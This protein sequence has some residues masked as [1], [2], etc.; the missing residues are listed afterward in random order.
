MDPRPYNYEFRRPRYN[1]PTLYLHSDH[2]A[3]L[4]IC[5]KVFITFDPTAGTLH[6][7]PSQTTR[8]TSLYKSIG[9]KDSSMI[10]TIKSKRKKSSTHQFPKLNIS[11]NKKWGSIPK[12]KEKNGISFHLPVPKTA[13]QIMVTE[14]WKTKTEFIKGRRR[15]LISLRTTRRNTR[16]FTENFPS[17]LSKTT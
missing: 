14:S 1:N 15:L 12:I 4:T 11:A 16:M 2:I 5:T 10:K 17:T 6:P 8:E 13:C 3:S 7:L 9:K